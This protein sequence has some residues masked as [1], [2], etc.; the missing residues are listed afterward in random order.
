MDGNT[1]FREFFSRYLKLYLIND[2]GDTIREVGL[3]EL[4]ITLK[5]DAYERSEEIE[6][7]DPSELFSVLVARSGFIYQRDTGM[8]AK[9]KMSLKDNASVNNG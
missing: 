7:T 9:V 4:D 2:R 6:V 8:A 5:S 1:N 3:N